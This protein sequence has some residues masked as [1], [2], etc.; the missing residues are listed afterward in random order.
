MGASKKRTYLGGLL[1]LLSLLL[2]LYYLK[3]SLISLRTV[4]G[5]SCVQEMEDVV[6]KIH[7]WA[8]PSNHQMSTSLRETA[9]TTSSLGSRN[10]LKINYRYKFRTQVVIPI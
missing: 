6:I 9:A 2:I 5:H 4:Y 7:V 8:R 10:F 3:E 1:I